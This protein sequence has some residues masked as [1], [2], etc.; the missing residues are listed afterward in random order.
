MCPLVNELKKREAIQT[1][2]CVMGQHRQML[3]Q[4]LNTFG[5]VPDYD[6]AIMK[7]CQILF[8]IT[9][10]ILTKIKNVLEMEKTDICLVHCDTTT[11]YVKA[12]ACFYLQIDVGHV[13]AGLRT[14]NIYSP[15]PEE[16]NRQNERLRPKYYKMVLSK[17]KH[18]NVAKTAVARELAC[19]I[20]GMM[21]DRIA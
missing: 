20:W 21:M 9:T 2:V 15:Y 3:D 5:V 1:I 6:L 8:D 16:F 13:E 17:S 18:T 19:F 10:S 4:V 12:L 11:I 7:Q 14:N